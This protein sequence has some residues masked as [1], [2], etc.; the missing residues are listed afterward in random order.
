M[1]SFQDLGMFYRLIF[2]YKFNLRKMNS[3]HKANGEDEVNKEMKVGFVCFLVLFVLI[4][5]FVSYNTWVCE[6]CFN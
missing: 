5:A 4:L 1:I 2:K 6:G 3:A